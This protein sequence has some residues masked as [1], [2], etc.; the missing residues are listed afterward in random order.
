M[1]LFLSPRQD[2][3]K[4]SSNIPFTRWLPAEYQDEISLPKGWDRERRVNNEILPLVMRFRIS[5]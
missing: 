5:S 4:G 2:T 1:D 3:R